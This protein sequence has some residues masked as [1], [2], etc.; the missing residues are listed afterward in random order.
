M[1]EKH[2]MAKF[3][4]IIPGLA[5]MIFTL[6]ILRLY[7]EPWM[8]DAVVLGQKGWLVKVLHLN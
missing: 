7:V 1:E 2:G 8:K 4:A 6:Y 3:M 5:F